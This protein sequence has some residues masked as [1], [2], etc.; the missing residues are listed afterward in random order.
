MT[1]FDHSSN[2]ASCFPEKFMKCGFLLGLALVSAMM[3][4]QVIAAENV[5]LSIDASKSHG[6]SS[7]FNDGR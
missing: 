2:N 6:R 4:V 3:P 1:S 7:H 5:H